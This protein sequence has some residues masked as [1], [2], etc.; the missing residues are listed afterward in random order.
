MLAGQFL[1]RC[2]LTIGEIS[3]T[4]GRYTMTKGVKTDHIFDRIV[5]M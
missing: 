2:N 3:D 1:A 5:G 4:V